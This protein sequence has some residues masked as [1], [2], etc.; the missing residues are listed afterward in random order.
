[1]RLPRMSTAALTMRVPRRRGW[2]VPISGLGARGD[3]KI[4]L[5]SRRRKVADTVDVEQPT[6]L[7]KPAPTPRL[8]V[9]T[10]AFPG[11]HQLAPDLTMQLGGDWRF[12]LSGSQTARASHNPSSS[13]SV[14]SKMAKHWFWGRPTRFQAAESSGGTISSGSCA[15]SSA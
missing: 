11:E 3:H 7:V 15:K 9:E 1:M 5:S 8:P 13:D 12:G 10:S 4:G 6:C 14:L 2:R